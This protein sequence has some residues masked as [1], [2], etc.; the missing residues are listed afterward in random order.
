MKLWKSILIL[1][2][3]IIELS[4]SFEFTSYNFNYSTFGKYFHNTTNINIYL[5]LLI[6]QIYNF[7]ENVTL[8]LYDDVKFMANRLDQMN[9]DAVFGL[10]LAQGKKFHQYIYLIIHLFI[11]LPVVLF[12]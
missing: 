2:P 9:A 8:A 7:T 12:S 11:Y 6:I 1:F 4:Q 5:S 10:T 3:S